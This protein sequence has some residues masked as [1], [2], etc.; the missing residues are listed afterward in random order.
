MGRRPVS[1]RQIKLVSTPS[2][3]AICL[4][5]YPAAILNNFRNVTRISRSFPYGFMLLQTAGRSDDASHSE[6]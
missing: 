1:Y 2:M 6:A 3:L 4:W 5:L